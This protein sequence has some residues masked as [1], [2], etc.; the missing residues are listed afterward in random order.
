MTP[1]DIRQKA[2]EEA[3]LSVDEVA[4]YY[5]V[6]PSTVYNLIAKGAL[7]ARKVG[8]FLRIPS[9]EAM[10]LGLLPRVGQLNVTLR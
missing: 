4:L 3:Y 1:D 7:G 8:R 10:T 2:Q 5:R 9:K 6:P